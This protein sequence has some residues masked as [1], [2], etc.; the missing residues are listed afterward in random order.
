MK[1]VIIVTIVILSIMLLSY[2]IAFIVYHS[3]KEK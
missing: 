1:E 2:I 3:G